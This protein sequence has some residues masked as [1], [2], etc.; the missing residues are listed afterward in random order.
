MFAVH[1]CPSPTPHT[2][3][4]D[5][6]F[7]RMG[8]DKA[9]MSLSDAN[10][11]ANH[12][13]H[14]LSRPASPLFSLLPDRWLNLPFDRAHQELPELGDPSHQP[15]VGFLRTVLSL[16]VLPPPQ[17]LPGFSP[18]PCFCLPLSRAVIRREHCTVKVQ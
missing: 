11:M 2:Q 4:R 3:H 10:A 8:S 6:I 13:Q 1:W 18:S 14:P 17:F 9:V 16:C 7:S 5:S 15:G 12:L